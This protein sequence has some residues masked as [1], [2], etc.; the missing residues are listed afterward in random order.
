MNKNKQEL[1][2]SKETISRN[3]D[4]IAGSEGLVDRIF[5]FDYAQKADR[6]AIY[7]QT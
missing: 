3:S 2:C 5:N 6:I 1:L 4:K 7:R